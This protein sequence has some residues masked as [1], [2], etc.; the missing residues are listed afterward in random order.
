VSL[1]CLS[2]ERFHVRVK[3]LAEVVVAGLVP[4]IPIALM[5]MPL[6]V[7]LKELAKLLL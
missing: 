2:D 1:Q 4:F 7:I 6:K 5:V 3:N